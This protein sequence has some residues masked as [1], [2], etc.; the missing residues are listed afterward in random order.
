MVC[1]RHI[2]WNL[3]RERGFAMNKKRVRL[4]YHYCCKCSLNVVN[5]LMTHLTEKVKAINQ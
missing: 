4:Q 5:G 1:A 2:S 3:K